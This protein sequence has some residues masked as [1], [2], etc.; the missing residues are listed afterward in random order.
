MASKAK[1]GSSKVLLLLALVVVIAVGAV[2]FLILNN[3]KATSV[4]ECS[5][6]PNVQFVLD[7]NNKVMKI[8]YLNTDAEIL[9]KDAKLEGKTADEA[10]KMFVQ[11]STEAGYIQA[12]TT[13]TRVDITISC[14]K[15]EDLEELEA[16]VVEKVNEYFDENG[17]IAGAVASVQEGFSDA[18][19][20][21]GVKASEIA[22]KTNAQV[23]ALLDER[24][25]EIEDIALSLQ[26][27]LFTF[28]ENLKNGAFATLDTLESSIDSIQEQ[29]DELDE[30][31][32]DSKVNEALKEIARAT[33]EQLQK[34][35][36]EA[37]KQLK[38]LNKEFK[39]K[40]NEK[41]EELKELSKEI[42][43]QA[44]TTL[45]SKINDAKAAI[46]AHKTNFENNKQA[47]L[48]AIQEYRNS[49]VA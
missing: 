27:N 8:N 32:Q 20:K 16:K 42:F 22:N 28:I 13:G 7:Q 46:Q 40:V 19:Q 35:I 24:S 11:L 25:A 44:K 17:I 2:V 29:I 39:A 31:I 14:D 23:I 10:A 6:N 45:Q 18:I 30:Q 9:L 21:I 47:T 49:L 15:P 1:K 3:K 38:E 4:M 48:D 37:Q 26:N 12:S 33:K 5:V 43:E 36:D 34:Q 41:I